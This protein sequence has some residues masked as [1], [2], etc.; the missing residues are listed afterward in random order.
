MKILTPEEESAV[1]RRFTDRMEAETQGSTSYEFA[2]DWWI[3]LSSSDLLQR[4]LRRGA[5]A[6]AEGGRA[7]SRGVTFDKLGVRG[8]G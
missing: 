4:K 2:R 8:V 6:P 7:E 1:E 3:P 5:G